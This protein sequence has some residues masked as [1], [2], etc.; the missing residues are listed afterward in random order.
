MI[1][2]RRYE[3]RI[4]GAEIG[5]SRSPAVLTGCFELCETSNAIKISIDPA[6]LNVRFP[7]REISIERLWQNGDV[8][9]R[10]V[11]RS[12][13]GDNNFASEIPARA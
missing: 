7:E 10:C 12:D 5:N 8:V 9:C 2:Y 13:T 3:T 4:K 1:F 11:Y 6:R